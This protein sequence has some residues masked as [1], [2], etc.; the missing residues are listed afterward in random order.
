MKTMYKTTVSKNVRMEQ[1]LVHQEYKKMLP[2]LS[3]Q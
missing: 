3:L 2:L 1:S